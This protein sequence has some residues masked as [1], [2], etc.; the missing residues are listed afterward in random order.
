[1]R[2]GGGEALL[3]VV[4]QQ[5]VRQVDG[6][7]GGALGEYALPRVGLELGQVGGGAGGAHRPQLALGGRA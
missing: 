2:L 7:A 4:A 3:R 5:L 6:P 1:M